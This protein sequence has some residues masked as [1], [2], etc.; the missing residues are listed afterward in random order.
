MHKDVVVM[1]G[2]DGRT[3][4]LTEREK[5]RLSDISVVIQPESKQLDHSLDVSTV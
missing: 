4:A 5:I 3:S 1:R 2:T